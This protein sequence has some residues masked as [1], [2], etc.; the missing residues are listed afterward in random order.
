MS[1]T[2]DLTGDITTLD[3]QGMGKRSARVNIMESIGERIEYNSV[4]H[5]KAWIDSNGLHRFS[6]GTFN[7]LEKHNVLDRMS[8]KTCT[9]ICAL[10]EHEV[11]LQEQIEFIQGDVSTKVQQNKDIITFINDRIEELY[12]TIATEDDARKPR[13]TF[14]LV[15]WH[16]WMRN[17]WVNNYVISLEDMVEY[18]A[19]V[20]EQDLE[21][22]ARA[23]KRRE[24][25]DRMIKARELNRID[26]DQFSKK[27][28]REQSEIISDL[29]KK[30][31]REEVITLAALTGEA[32]QYEEVESLEY[33]NN[34][35]HKQ[36]L[37]Q[38]EA[39]T[40]KD[41]KAASIENL[42]AK[43]NSYTVADVADDIAT[44]CVSKLHEYGKHDI[45]YQLHRT[46]IFDM[47]ELVDLCTD[48]D[49]NIYQVMTNFIERSEEDVSTMI[50]L[51]AILTQRY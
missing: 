17:R 35:L 7:W 26:K 33:E 8:Y 11:D 47:A 29:N 1:L 2:I 9:F 27:R 42:V 16:K 15:K 25:T 48:N 6:T 37:E 40:R 38:E 36:L 51:T 3:S 45:D 24:K 19:K 34:G 46:F 43:L 14:W 21:D 31:K 18:Q 12:E 23:V 10:T 4:A 32:V 30:I 44:Q 49:N 50:D 39:S 5:Q 13:D 22:T 28:E 41:S 20:A